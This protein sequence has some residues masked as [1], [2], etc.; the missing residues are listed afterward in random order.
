MTFGAV[1]LKQN[2]T[3]IYFDFDKRDHTTSMITLKQYK[4]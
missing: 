4:M 1:N 3:F 2:S